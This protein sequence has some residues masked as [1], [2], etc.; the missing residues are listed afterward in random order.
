MSRERIIDLLKAHVLYDDEDGPITC[1]PMP[2]TRNFSTHWTSSEESL[3][4]NHPHAELDEWHAHLADILL[5]LIEAEKAHCA[6][7]T[8]GCNCGYGGMH[9]PEN[10]R[11]NLNRETETPE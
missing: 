7:C 5:P 10:P 8:C 2:L 6:T 9:E 3:E 11:C 1:G 4:A